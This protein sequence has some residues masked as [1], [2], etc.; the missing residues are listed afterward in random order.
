MVTFIRRLQRWWQYQRVHKNNNIDS[1]G[2]V[3]LC[4]NVN[5]PYHQSEFETLTCHVL[6]KIFPAKEILV[7]AQNNCKTKF[8]FLIPGKF[9]IE[10]H[11]VWESRD[12]LDYL[13][14]YFQRLTQTKKER[15]TN[16]LPVIVLSSYEDLRQFYKITQT[17]EN[18]D[19]SIRGLIQILLKKYSIKDISTT[20]I[21]Y[22]P[23]SKSR[24]LIYLIIS[25]FMEFLLIF[26]SNFIN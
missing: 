6:H 16:G 7:P 1:Y 15:K 8:D 23:I 20:R 25:Y 24:I 19:R 13:K 5:H 10:P 4:S 12:G 3:S 9:I 17:S 26:I 14:Y 11:A 2:K 18:I 22:Q 21:H